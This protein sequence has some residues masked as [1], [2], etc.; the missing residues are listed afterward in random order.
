MAQRRD[1]EVARP[2]G[3]HEVDREVGAAEQRDLGSD[4]HGD[5]DVGGAEV[6][7]LHALLVGDLEHHGTGPDVAARGPQRQGPLVLVGHREVRG[8]RGAE[9]VRGGQCDDPRPGGLHVGAQ[10]HLLG[11]VL[12]H[13]DERAA[14]DEGQAVVAG[15]H[16][17]QG[18]R[19]LAVLVTDDVGDGVRVVEDPDPHLPSF[20]G[21][22]GGQHGGRRAAS[23]GHRRCRGRWRARPPG[24]CPGRPRA[25]RRRR[26][27][28]AG[29]WRRGRGAR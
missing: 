18:H 11:G 6:L 3:R 29:S 26:P 27:R 13:L 1:V 21:A 5:G 20:D 16:V 25:W 7:L 14:H 22:L 17:D 4:L 10:R 8:R 28:P 23:S 15:R 19:R 12:V 2:P 9:G 24:R